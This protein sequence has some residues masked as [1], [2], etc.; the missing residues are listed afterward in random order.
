MAYLKVSN[1]LHFRR[2]HVVIETSITGPLFLPAYYFDLSYLPLSLI[3][4]LFVSVSCLSV[5][6]SAIQCDCF[7]VTQILD[8]ESKKNANLTLTIYQ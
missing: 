7:D 8:F 5:F 1:V 3:L 2:D 4:E 6:M